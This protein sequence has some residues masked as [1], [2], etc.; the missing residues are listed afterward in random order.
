MLRSL[1]L[2]KVWKSKLLRFL[3]SAGSA[4]FVTG[5]H[6]GFPL[7]LIRVMWFFPPMC[8]LE[9]PAILCYYADLRLYK[10]SSRI[11]IHHDLRVMSRCR[12]N[13]GY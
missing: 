12:R 13:V 1:K 10:P 11:I 6:S 9:E 3:A 5:L 4:E 7:P 8:S 2:L